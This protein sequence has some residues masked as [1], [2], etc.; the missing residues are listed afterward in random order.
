M[1]IAAIGIVSLFLGLP[2][3]VDMGIHCPKCE[4][5]VEADW[6]YCPWDGVE[7]KS[8]CG[9]C[10]KAWDKSFDFCPKCSTPLGKEGGKEK[11]KR[12]VSDKANTPAGVVEHF[13]DALRVGDR[14]LLEDLVHWESYHRSYLTKEDLEEKDLGLEAFKKMVQKQFINEKVQEKVKAMVRAANG[15]KFTI[16]GDSARFEIVLVNP[17]DQLDRFANIIDLRS[18]NGQWM[19]TGV[20]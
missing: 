14:K 18:F 6:N 8:I 3:A 19:I 9:E 13:L 11:P 17:K 16:V 7:L 10:T 20:T 4:K 1:S 2:S 12:K 5:G 15:N